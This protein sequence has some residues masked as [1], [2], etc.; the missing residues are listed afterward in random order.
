M[1]DIKKQIADAQDELEGLLEHKIKKLKARESVK[2]PYGRVIKTKVT[3][4]RGEPLNRIKG[5][6]SN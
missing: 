5:D 4:A 2:D 6:E 1:T 3:N